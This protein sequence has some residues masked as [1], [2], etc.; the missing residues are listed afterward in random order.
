MLATRMFFWWEQEAAPAAPV[1]E[2][3]K[4][5]RG[6]GSG[7]KRKKPDYTP[8]DSEFWEIRE[9][10]LKRLMEDTHSI[11]ST[12]LP[13]TFDSAKLSR[14][15][16]EQQALIDAAHYASSLE[17]LQSIG[18]RLRELNSV[19]KRAKKIKKFKKLRLLALSAA[20]LSLLSVN[21]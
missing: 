7:G 20:L 15:L 2:Q 21:S 14:Y 19:V 11:D 5:D 1:P 9:R 17:A 8:A 10:Y 3:P 16:S 4:Q 6:A 12:H 13:P 18:N